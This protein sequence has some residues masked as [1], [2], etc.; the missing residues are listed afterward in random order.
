[1]S[2]SDRRV[3]PVAREVIARFYGRVTSLHD[4]DDE[5]DDGLQRRRDWT[6]LQACCVPV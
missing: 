2:P 6:R 3:A 4:D 1:M 5:D